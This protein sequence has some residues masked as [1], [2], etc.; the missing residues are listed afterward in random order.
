MQAELHA[1][2][3]SPHAAPAMPVVKPAPVPRAVLARQ[4]PARRSD[5][6]GMAMPAASAPDARPRLSIDYGRVG[7]PSR[8]QP[9]PS[10]QRSSPSSTTS[11][12]M[13]QGVMTPT[14]SDL[15]AQHPQQQPPPPPFL[16][17]PPHSQPAEMV[18]AAHLKPAT[19]GA[20]GLAV[21]ALGPD[22]RHA[23]VMPP[24]Y[25]SAPFQNHFHQLG[26]LT[27]PRPCAAL[28]F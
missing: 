20:L 4:H 13:A 24:A 7:P 22:A 25:Y 12:M 11:G 21:A 23:I 5:V 17:P 18:D 3:G 16:A 8:L 1:K 9:T 10:S 2:T 19:T 6:T 15:S 27:R 28:A 14:A 26:K